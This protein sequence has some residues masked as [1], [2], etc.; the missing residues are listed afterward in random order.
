MFDA[1][2]QS[3]PTAPRNGTWWVNS[4]DSPEQRAFETDI[5]CGPGAPDRYF[6]PPD[7]PAEDNDWVLVLEVSR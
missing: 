4:N 6:F 5:A 7:Q 1:S 3:R 2:R